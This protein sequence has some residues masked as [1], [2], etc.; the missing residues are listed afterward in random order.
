MKNKIFF[1]AFAAAAVLAGC[2]VD[3]EFDGPSLND[4]YGQFAIVQGLDVSNDNVDFSSGETTHFT[5]QFSKN[6]DWKLTVT[7]LE[8]GAV[9]EITGF[10]NLLDATNALWEGSTT[11]LPL[12]KAEECAVE[13]TFTA[14]VDTLRDT[15]MIAGTK[16]YQ[17]FVLSDFETGTNPDWVTFAQS[18]ANMSFNVATSATAAQGNSYFDI[19]GVVDWDWLIGL[20]HM[21]GSAYG[22]VHFPL[23]EN[24]DDEFFNVMLYKEPTLSNGLVLFQFREDDNNDGVFTENVEDMYSVEINMSE[25][26]WKLYSYK[27]G[28]LATL[29]N[30]QPSAAIGN[31]VHEPHKLIQIS[32]LFLANPN[33][34]YAHTYMDYLTFTQGGPLVP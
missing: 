3:D 25:N 16:T 4:L 19:G 34:G 32:M 13:L 21:P 5:A 1:L 6:V 26:G 14:E 7:G 31:G 27:Y 23:S 29:I 15:L 17:G 9:K 20:I 33:S 11:R 18:G 28:D 24:P 10:T 12:F 30:G 8:S 2:K 22:D